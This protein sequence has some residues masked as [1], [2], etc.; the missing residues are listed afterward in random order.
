MRP[1]RYLRAP[2][3]ILSVVARGTVLLFATTRIAL[4]QPGAVP[5]RVEKNTSVS[6][7]C[8]ADSAASGA[9]S[10]DR[11]PCFADI[12]ATLYGHAV[13]P[14]SVYAEAVRQRQR[15]LATL[16]DAGRAAF[17][18]SQSA[19][20]TLRHVRTDAALL[21]YDAD[22]V[23]DAYRARLAH[24]RIAA[25]D[26]FKEFPVAPITVQTIPRDQA[27]NSAPAAYIRATSTSP[28]RLLVNAYQPGGVARM[29]VAFGTAHE[30][31]PGHHFQRLYSDAHGVD[32]R[33]NPNA[34]AF[35]E[36]WGIYAEQL[37]DESGLYDQPLDRL[38]YLTHLLD[39]FMAL[40][41][42]VGMHAFGWTEAQARDTMMVVAGR[43]D[44]QAEA[45]ARRHTATPGQLASYGI[46]YLAIIAARHEAMAQLG[47][48]F[49]IRE[50][51]DVVLRD[52]SVPLPV[53]VDH[54]TKWIAQLRT[55]QPL[56]GRP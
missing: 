50:F 29:N 3:A 55:P 10:R 40:Q 35:S 6:A 53:M 20:E 32:G 46:G 21:M 48:R 47:T 18:T 38:G 12:L 8:A 14:E 1:V 25:H 28:A 22:S 42:D 45:Y 30:A 37:G 56:Q 23:L 19:I 44:V 5:S 13:A 41:I 4:A 11:T 34:S 16:P 2:R 51:H 49:D 52:G 17:S 27:P 31:Y 24:A 7:R 9:P 36:G 43:S 54:V 15:I 39:V 26:L 33:F